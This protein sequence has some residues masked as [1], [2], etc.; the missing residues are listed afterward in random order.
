MLINLRISNLN[1]LGREQLKRLDKAT[2]DRETLTVFLQKL[3][4]LKAVEF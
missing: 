1:V 3:S 2:N 4:M